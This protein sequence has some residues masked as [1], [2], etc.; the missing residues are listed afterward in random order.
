MLGGL[1][2]TSA[3]SSDAFSPGCWPG[4]VS[5]AR[6]GWRLQ[7]GKR[8]PLAWLNEFR[9][10][11]RAFFPPIEG[12][13]LAVLPKWKRPQPTQHSHSENA[14]RAPRVQ[15]AYHISSTI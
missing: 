7:I 1:T 13:R 9:R 4:A 14:A 8:P 3:P 5:G 12:G 15:V 2:G 11:P 10:V 6:V